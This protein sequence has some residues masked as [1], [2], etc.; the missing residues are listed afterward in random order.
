MN[1]FPPAMPLLR[2]TVTGVSLWAGVTVGLA[3]EPVPGGNV[4]TG[5][6]E[7]FFESEVRPFLSMPV[8]NAVGAEIGVRPATGQCSGPTSRRRQRSGDGRRQPDESLLLQV[9]GYED[10]IQMPP[11]EKLAESQIEVLRKWVRLGAPW[12]E[13]SVDDPNPLGLRAG[14]IADAERQHWAYQPVRQPAVPDPMTALPNPDAALAAWAE[15]DID[16]FILS[17]LV[18]QGL[19][20]AGDAT[21]Q[22]SLRRLSFDLI[23][24]PPTPEE[25]ADFLADSS[26]E[27]SRT[28]SIDCSNRPSTASAGD[29]TGWTWFVMPTPRATGQIIPSAKLIV[30]V[31]M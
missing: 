7:R 18:A 11:D 4:A 28:L 16:R 30:I 15:T 10:A 19:R 23:G 3:A 25:V 27:A 13:E 26:A 31:I 2:A 29:G 24:L 6:V 22:Q 17:G 12:P 14:P 20:P 8:V 9:I 5:E 1:C 21:K